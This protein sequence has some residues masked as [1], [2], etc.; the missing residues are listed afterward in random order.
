MYGNLSFTNH[1]YWMHLE[2]VNTLKIPLSYYL[3]TA[4]PVTNNVDLYLFN[5]E[6]QLEVQHSGD[7]LDYKNRALIY[8][9]TLLRINLKPQEKKSVYNAL[10]NAGEKNTLPQVLHSQDHLLK[11]FYHEQLIFGLFYGILMTIVI[12]YIFFFFALKEITFLYYSL[13]ILFT[14]LYHAALDGFFHQYIMTGDSWFNLHAVLI[15]AIAGSCF[16][17]NTARLP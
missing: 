12:T 6:H 17:V 2:L 1:Q 16:S 8:R 13:Y 9:K 10:K 14:C 15:F 4:E 3:E 7:D 11:D 5:P